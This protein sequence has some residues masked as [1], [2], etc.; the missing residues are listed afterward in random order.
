MDENNSMTMG[1]KN[2]FEANKICQYFS[3]I[4]SFSPRSGFRVYT[5]T[6]LHSTFYKSWLFFHSSGLFK[7]GIMK[8]LRYTYLRANLNHF[9]QRFMLLTH[10][11]NL[12]FQVEA[13]QLLCEFFFSSIYHK[14]TRSSILSLQFIALNLLDQCSSIYPR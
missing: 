9:W 13:N 14:E 8:N 4:H 11:L 3:W 5:S 7:I 6:L 10:Y 1:Y 12:I 2:K